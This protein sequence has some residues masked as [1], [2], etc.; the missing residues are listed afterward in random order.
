MN[1]RQFLA[2]LSV[3][4]LLALLVP[5]VHAQTSLEDFDIN[6]IIR[7]LGPRSYMPELLFDIM[8]YLIFII[9]FITMLL[10]PDKQ[11]L[12]SLLMVSVLGMVV[13]AKLEIFGATELPTLGITCGIFVLPLIVAGMLRGRGKTPK[14]LY[15]AIITGFLGGGYFFLFWALAQRN[16]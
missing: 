1:R 14:A 9:G 2:L 11:L 8:R 10:V 12:A 5:S 16:A 3:I 7:Q 15:P 13:F 6:Q 4:L